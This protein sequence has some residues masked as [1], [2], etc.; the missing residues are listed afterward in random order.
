MLRMT[1]NSKVW[2]NSLVFFLHFINFN[3]CTKVNLFL[4]IS[5]NFPKSWDFL[6]HLEAK[7]SSSAKHWN[8][9]SIYTQRKS[10][11]IGLSPCKKV[12]FIYFN[13]SLLKMMK[14]AYFMLKTLF[15]LRIFI[16]VS[17]LSGHLGQQLVKWFALN[18][19][20]PVA[21]PCSRN[22]VKIQF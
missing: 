14:N 5:W 4:V 19:K 9:I 10:L 3:N 15:I 17:W 8:N 12:A 16:F 7:K 21:S 2:I 11:K 18:K 6:E 22:N 20:K 1:W 13:E